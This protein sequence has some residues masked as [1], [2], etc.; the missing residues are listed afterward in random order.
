MD[1]KAIKNEW[2]REQIIDAA[3]IY[4]DELAGKVFLYVY[5]ETYF[6]VVFLTECFRHLTGVNSSISAKEFY[7]KA[8]NSTLSTGQIF[9]DAK[10]TYSG[11]KKKLPC[12]MALPSLTNDVV[13]V[14]KDMQTI[15]VTYKIG[16][17]N[18]NFTIGL[19][20]N[21]NRAGDKVNDWLLPRTLRVKDKAIE[22]SSDAEFV[23]FIFSKD[24]SMVKYSTINYSDIGKHPPLAIKGFLSDGLVEQLYPDMR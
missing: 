4:R 22:N 2:I 8:K 17:T 10:H 19:S 23:D 16:V 1:T 24:A 9:Y 13:C 11:A 12:L 3:K 20:E 6:E 7:N 14:V 5:G 15:S 21:R 18:L